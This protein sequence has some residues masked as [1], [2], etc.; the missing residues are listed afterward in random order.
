M[1]STSSGSEPD[2]SSSAACDPLAPP[3]TTL[4]TVL[5]V[6]K[7]SSGIL[8]VADDDMAAGT[9]RVF[10]SNGHTLERQHVLGSGQS[11]GGQDAQYTVSFESRDS[12]GSDARSLLLNRQGGMAIAM[13]IG[14]AGSKSFLSDASVG[15]TPLTVEDVA[16]V[17][18]LAILNLP[19]VIQYVG[20]VSNA[21]VLVVT[22]QMDVY[23]SASFRIFYGPPSNMVEGTITDFTQ[24]LSGYPTITFAIG[25]TTYTMAISTVY[26]PEGG[27]LGEPGPGTLSIAGGPTWG[28]TL[29]LPPPRTLAGLQ[30]LC[31]VP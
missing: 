2:A 9:L 3:A 31:L 6:G 22:S 28:F 25:S 21:E 1:G 19:G 30:F 17:S 23:S 14:P 11:G 29:R 5:G 24:A 26:P 20:D 13:A 8:Y 15:D 10:V 12:D 4:A 18:A 16:A 7:D 27:P